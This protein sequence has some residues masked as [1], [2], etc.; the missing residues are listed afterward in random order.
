MLHC[1][2][3]HRQSL[4]KCVR[5]NRTIAAVLQSCAACEYEIAGE[6]SPES[7]GD[8]FPQEPEIFDIALQ[9]AARR[10]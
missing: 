3:L 9:G 4:V 6:H 1:I 7:W 10:A 8:R 5:S 2:F